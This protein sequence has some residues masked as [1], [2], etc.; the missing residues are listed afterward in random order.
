[1]YLVQLLLLS[2][3]VDRSR[4]P[5]GLSRV[6]LWTFLAQ[7]IVDSVSFAGHITFAIIANGRPSLSLVAPAFVACVLFAFESVSE[8]SLLI[9][10]CGLNW[11]FS[12]MPSSLIRFKPQRMQWRHPLP[13]QYNRNRHCLLKLCLHQQRLLDL[14]AR[15]SQVYCFDTFAL[16]PKHGYVGI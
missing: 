6:S 1:V 5:A 7:S 4:T 10:L 2:R 8:P 14:L 13:D 16:I 15:H 3:Q 12:N 11:L 9:R